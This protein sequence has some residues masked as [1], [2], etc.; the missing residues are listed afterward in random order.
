MEKT[1]T[2]NVLCIRGLKDEIINVVIGY[3]LPSNNIIIQN[4]NIFR[5][6]SKY[7]SKINQYKTQTINQLKTQLITD[8]AKEFASELLSNALLYLTNSTYK[9][10]GYKLNNEQYKIWKNNQDSFIYKLVNE[11]V[12][13]NN[14]MESFFIHIATLLIFLKPWK[15]QDD[16]QTNIYSWASDFG[17]KNFQDKILHYAFIPSILADMRIEHFLPTVFSNPSVS[18]DQQNQILNIVRH[19]IKI[20]TF[21]LL[22]KFRHFINPG[23]RAR[24]IGI[25]LFIPQK[26]SLF[27]KSN[28][29]N[30]NMVKN[31]K[32]S[33]LVFLKIDKSLYCLRIIDV[34]NNITLSNNDLENVINPIISYLENEKNT[35]ESSLQDNQ[36]ILDSSTTTPSQKRHLTYTNRILSK[37]LHIIDYH[38]NKLTENYNGLLP[39][40]FVKYFNITYPTIIKS[41]ID[42]SSIDEPSDYSKIDVDE[43]KEESKSELENTKFAKLW[44]IVSKDI[45]DRVNDY[46]N[47]TNNTLD[48]PDWII[49]DKINIDENVD[50][51]IDEY[52]DP[53]IID[54]GA[55]RHDHKKNKPAVISRPP[56][57]Y[58]DDDEYDDDDDDDDK[59]DDDDEE[60]EYDPIFDDSSEE[61]EGEQKFG[62][63]KQNPGFCYICKQNN[64]NKL[65]YTSIHGPNGFK[66]IK[67]CLPCMEQTQ[68]KQKKRSKF[69]KFRSKFNQLRL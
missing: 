49:N 20:E 11:I 38:L 5:N 54:G 30:S 6:K 66:R 41:E 27:D 12:K 26:I 29:I 4:E 53:K 8:N 18:T 21:K 24:D 28:C 19:H 36:H 46:K 2:G 51:D 25:P 47:N 17:I 68:F 40:D 45:K 1:Q 55:W 22:N 52:W 50:D 62:M 9:H 56:G 32:L 13:K 64:N 61:D 35:K 58:D 16:K 33:N 48:L 34:Q 57:Y 7:L 3:L 37:R 59:D 44:S 63:S 31:D 60:E 69:K 65:V 14:N 23:L 43:L 42:P 39:V 10:L 67:I 15:I